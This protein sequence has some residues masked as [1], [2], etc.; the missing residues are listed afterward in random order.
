LDEAGPGGDPEDVEDHV[1]LPEPGIV[2]GNETMLKVAYFTSYQDWLENRMFDLSSDANAND[3]LDRWVALKAF[4][5]ELD[6]DL[7]TYDVYASTREPD[8][9]LVQECRKYEL[10]FLRKHRINPRKAIPMLH[11]PPVVHPWQW[12]KLPYYAWL[13]KVILTWN[14]QLCQ[15]KKFRHYHFP[16]TFKAAKY[17]HYRANEKR[18]LCLMMHSH[19]T[20]DVPGE[21]YSLRRRIIRG[22]EQRGG[23]LLD[24]YGF[25]WNSDDPAWLRGRVD[26]FYTPLYKGTTHDKRET[27]S[28]Y[29]FSICLDNCVQPG[30]VTYDPLISMAAGTVPVYLP[31]P[32]S[33]DFIP[34]DTFVNYADFDTLDDLVDHLQSLV[35]SGRYEE[36]RERGW[37]FIN[38]EAYRPFTVE[39]FCE[40]IHAA[41][42]EALE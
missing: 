36:Y 9:W 16:V 27:Y 11:E 1:R 15:R 7:N 37:A 34:Q 33:L 39:K 24:L 5:A 40:D 35:A 19:K 23:A 10:S 14:S 42:E 25:G 2:G 22:F 4:L 31:M 32:D 21:L 18:N 13:F 3:V 12:R 8:L 6:I 29:H 30:Y 20:S 26:P 17:P 38:S 28:E 41:I